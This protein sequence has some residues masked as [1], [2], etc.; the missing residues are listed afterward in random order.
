[1]ATTN[2][3]MWLMHVHLGKHGEPLTVYPTT[4]KGIVTV[5]YG[6]QKWETIPV[7]EAEQIVGHA[8]LHHKGQVTL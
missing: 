4:K 6:K 2:Y 1:M 7:K 8:M 3:N 5:M